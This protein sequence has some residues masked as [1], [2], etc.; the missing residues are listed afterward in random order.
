M[1]KSKFNIALVTL[2]FGTI[3]CM[4][5]Q[6]PISH[7]DNSQAVQLFIRD[8][9]TGKTAVINAN[10]GD[11]I[12]QIRKRV[13]DITGLSSE[14]QQLSL[15][16]KV[17]NRKGSLSSCGIKNE[18]FLNLLPRNALKG[19]VVNGISFIYS[20]LENGV[21]KEITNNHWKIR[22]VLVPDRIYRK[23]VQQG[24]HNYRKIRSGFNVEGRCGYHACEANGRMVWTTKIRGSNKRNGEWEVIEKSY[25]KFSLGKVASRAVCPLCKKRLTSIR[26]CGFYR[27]SYHI[28]GTK[29]NGDDLDDKGFIYEHNRFKYF[30]D[31]NLA[32]WVFVDI[33]V[34]Y[35][36]CIIL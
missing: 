2:V 15:A 18:A 17:L 36:Y 30:S 25:G 1:N 28:D 21:P 23:D 29:T 4:E 22:N 6:V 34:S 9:T 13:Y 10:L 19:G 12:G 3:A 20:L 35:E 33:D 16:G 11:D 27:C 8:F 7:M 24:V 14:C 26:S 31:E 5:F 32:T